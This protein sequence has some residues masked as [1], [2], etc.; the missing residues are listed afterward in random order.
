MSEPERL[1]E[2]T[3]E[4]CV[5]W[6][7]D[8]Q[9]VY[10]HL[11]RYAFA[12]ELVAGKVVLDLGSG[13]GYGSALLG[14]T[15][16]SVLGLDI[17]LA[18]IEHSRA[19]HDVDAVTFAQGSAEELASRAPGEFDVVVCYEV[20]EH[21]TQ[22]ESVVD[23]IG[24]V[25]RDDGILILSTPDREP[26]NAAIAEPNPFHL[27]EVTAVELHELLRRRFAR[28]RMW[29][30]SAILGSRIVAEEDD[31]P[32]EAFVRYAGGS[33][34]RTT[35]PQS[36]YL[37]AVASNAPLPG[38]PG[39]SHLYDV[40]FEAVNRSLIRAAEAEAR[41]AELGAQLSASM[42]QLAAVEHARAL[43]T[44]ELASL[45]RQPFRRAA[46]TYAGARLAAGRL[47]RRARARWTTQR[48]G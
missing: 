41:A 2:W 39:R 8:V 10:E 34:S 45:R 22:H 11:H 40:G 42:E 4:R 44:A 48:P 23:G 25:L 31:R 46:A 24:H 26:Y 6:S 13:E 29:R 5:P 3:G 7:D 38:L 36:M 12:E 30:Q 20:L 47:A 16:A 27:R 32:V 9:V 43:A 35:E 15:A 33:W 19:N 18:S 28:V 17:D 14:R 1:I 21:V 37:V